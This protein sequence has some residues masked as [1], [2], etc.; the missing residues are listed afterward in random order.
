MSSTEI[1]QLGLRDSLAEVDSFVM[2]IVNERKWTDS[3]DS[4]Q[5]VLNELK[6]NL[7]IHPNLEPLRALKILDKGV[8]LLRLQTMHRRRAEQI[9]K[10]IIKLNKI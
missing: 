5:K 3:N 9:Q 6:D 8:R 2:G 7:G 4:Y 10:A 1:L